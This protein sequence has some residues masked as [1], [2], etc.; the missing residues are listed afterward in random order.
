MQREIPSA[1]GFFTNSDRTLEQE[2]RQS[3]RP[4]SSRASSPQ[5]PARRARQ[6]RD[7]AESRRHLVASESFAAVSAELSR[8]RRSCDVVRD[9]FG[10][11]DG[12]PA[13]V[14]L[15]ADP[16]LAHIGRRVEHRL[17]LL[18]KELDPAEVDHRFAAPAQEDVAVLV[19]TREIAGGGPAVIRELSGISQT[20]L[21]LRKKRFTFSLSHR[22]EG[23]EGIRIKDGI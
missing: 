2:Q 8:R 20:S 11:R 10:D 17:D 13:F 15:T 4:R 21:P 18:R 7:Q 16:A 6:H 1:V 3:S 12:A 14:W 5:L 22:T 9:E 23:G 19:L